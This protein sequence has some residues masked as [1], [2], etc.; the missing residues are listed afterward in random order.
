MG[1]HRQELVFVSFGSDS[2]SRSFQSHCC[3]RCFTG[4]SVGDS[5]CNW[6]KV[7]LCSGASCCPQ[8]LFHKHTHT[9]TNRVHAASCFLFHFLLLL[10]SIFSALFLSLSSHHPPLV[11]LH[12][13]NPGLDSLCVVPQ[14]TSR[15]LLVSYFVFIQMQWWCK[16]VEG[17]VKKFEDRPGFRSTPDVVIEEETETFRSF[18]ISSIKVKK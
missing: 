10:H 2:R 5:V 13:T 11:P 14:L 17:W 6:A 16:P 18:V 3:Y 4:V 1:V 15:A 8:V 7:W 12:L 9:H